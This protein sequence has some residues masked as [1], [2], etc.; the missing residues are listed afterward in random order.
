MNK[1]WYVVHTYSGYEQKAK[2]ALEERIRALG[3]QEKFGEVLVPAEKVVELVKG[4]K[5]TSSRKFFPGYMLVNMELDEETWHI[6]KGTPKVAG[7]VGDATSPAPI[8]DSEVQEIAHQMAEGAV[9]PKPKV[10]F[11]SGESVKV[12]DGPFAD[13]NGVVEEV[14]SD[15]GKLRVLIS[16]FGR[17]TPVELDFVQVEKA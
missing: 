6:V 15:K 17:A 2:A 1:Q 7:F 4:R 13:F 9:R 11:E 5:K 14:K 3:K 8:S 12:V 16:I 10:L